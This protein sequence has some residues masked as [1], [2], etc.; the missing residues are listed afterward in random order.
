V[1]VRDGHRVTVSLSRAARRGAGLAYG[2]LPEGEI[3]LRNA[4]RAVSFRACRRGG[5]SGSSHGGRPVTF[6]S[7]FVLVASPRCVP[8]SVWVDDEP[9]PRRIWLRLGRRPCPR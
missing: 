3:G 6:W 9:E 7:G 4:H 8:L 1:L 5:P 2:P